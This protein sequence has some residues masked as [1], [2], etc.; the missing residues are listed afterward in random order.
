M[1]LGAVQQRNWPLV[2][3]VLV[4][5]LVFGLR[6]FGRRIHPWFVSR[7]AGVAL[8]A[9]TAAAGAVLTP[10]VTGVPWSVELIGQAVTAAFAAMGVAA[11]WQSIRK[12]GT[13]ER[14]AKKK[15][16][17]LAEPVKPAEPAKPVA[18]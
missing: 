4:F 5:G 12:G 14:H 13:S 2:A 8:A 6:T 11:G 10:L 17:T 3:A 18:L 1:L 7:R 9:A 16:V 15:P